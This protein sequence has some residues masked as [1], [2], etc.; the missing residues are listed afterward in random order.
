[1]TDTVSQPVP[2]VDTGLSMLL[3][4]CSMIS[5]EKEIRE[6]DD[7]V[8]SVQNLSQLLAK[9][10]TTKGGLTFYIDGNGD[11]QVH[12]ESY[13]GLQD[14]AKEKAYLLSTIPGISSTSIILLHFDTQRETIQWFW[15]VT[16]LGLLPA[17][18]TSFVHDTTRRQKHLIHLHKLLEKPVILTS[19]ELVPSFLDIAELRLHS[20]QSL[21]KKTETFDVSMNG[22]EKKA[23]E[24][25]VLMMTS[26]STGSAKAVP[27]GH[28]QLLTAIRGKISHHQTETRDVFLNWIGMDHVAS[29]CEI[30]LHALSLGSEQVHVPAPV[31]FRDPLQFIL[32]LDAHRVSYTFAPNF[33]LTQVRDALLAHG[34][35][36][37]ADL[38]CLKRI[39]SGGEANLVT[40]CDSLTR[41]LRRLGMRDGVV[42]PGFGMTETCAG[43]IHAQACPSYDVARGREF[44]SLGTC[45]PG[46]EMRVVRPDGACGLAAT[47]EVGE[48][49]L[50]G[51]VLFSGYFNDPT[52]TRDAF[53]HDGWFITGDLGWLDE[54]GN[55]NLAGRGKD[56]V[57]IN[58]VKW[59]A[60]EIEAAI[61][62]EGI[63]G[64]IPSFTAVF[65][66]RDPGSPTEEIAVV[67]RPKFAVDDLQTRV[68][69][70]VAV[71]NIIALLT[72]RKPGHSIP[73][74]ER[75]PE[76]SSLGK[77]SR[78]K[79]REA[80]NNGEYSAIEADH[81]RAVRGYQQAVWRPVTT[82]TEKKIQKILVELL[83]IRAEETG[84][85]TSIFDLGI[86][87]FNL[88][89][90]RAMIEGIADSSI[91]LPISILMTRPTVG[92]IA[93]SVDQLLSQP[94]EYNPIVPLQTNGSQTPLF[95]IH[96]GSG[97]VLVFIAL[98]TQFPNRPVYALRT[99]GYNRNEAVF[100]TMDEAAQT[101]VSHIRKTQPHGPYAVAGYSL[102]STL[103]FE[104]GKLLEAQGQ[105]VRFLASIDYPPHISQYVRGQDW[106]DVLLHISFFLELIDQ[107][108]MGRATAH[109]HTH[110]LSRQAALEYVLSIS[111]E[112]RV[113][114]LAL[115]PS[116]LNRICDIGENFRVHGETY[117]PVGSVANLDVFIADPPG[118]AAVDRRDWVENK[119]ARWKDFVRSIVEFYE[120]P[121]IH[122]RM[123]NPEMIPGFVKS[124]KL[125]MKRRGV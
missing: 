11:P 109:I 122:A 84:V 34:S 87:S 121:G 53:T 118:Y 107:E 23:D 4:K 6:S 104:V 71:S 93:A 101:Y 78:T 12:R 56:T 8:S 42:S 35:N 120:C 44:A 3:E 73:L 54:N 66:C 14:D 96:P 83:G 1:M 68:E 57:N 98:A 61:E 10:S 39:N 124:F 85:D 105:E 106:F 70:D 55:L 19:E 2:T 113:R 81:T 116:V 89:L 108:I 75:T 86:T 45:I 76:K 117:E 72:G 91:D 58:G 114:S 102:G 24:A 5:E 31:L 32:L 26:G 80:F 115:T 64:I 79:V 59:N 47:G 63:P 92:D 16:I 41:A 9:A 40:T 17:I 125:A 36:I 21:S 112:Q 119:L 90:L 29:M 30:H 52:A 50:S 111:D 28:G 94:P 25:A 27:L 100:S 95:L 51:A 18:S 49:Q 99:R 88:I 65:S 33:F 48:L 60:A 37:E 69:T 7:H 46:I 38:S 15:A 103:A 43:A 13:A 67:Y 20:V 77:I 97:D 62:E 123:L 22:A 82:D 110:S 74:F